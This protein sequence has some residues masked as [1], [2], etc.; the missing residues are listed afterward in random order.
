[1][2]DWIKIQAHTAQ[3]LLEHF[4]ISEENA[5]AELVPDTTPRISIERLAAKGF[6]L[7]AVKL[8][9]HALPKREAVWWACLAARA[10]QTPETDE[11]NQ[12]ALLA[13]EAWAKK[14]T[15]AHRLRARQ[16]G[17]KTKYRTPASWAAT[18]AA[19]S[20]G[21]MVDDGEPVVTP[22]EYLYA[23]AVAGAVCLA[24]VAKDEDDPAN[25]YQTFMAQGVNIACGGNGI[26]PVTSS[27]NKE[28]AHG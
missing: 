11:D 12:L 26:A 27:L 2:S 23:H 17:E 9:A 10:I 14:P 22:P 8:L 13:A 21:S 6:Y 19:W 20:A 18:A 1:M 5:E 7:D 3:E 4:E 15:E 28:L 16:L 25:A 24:A